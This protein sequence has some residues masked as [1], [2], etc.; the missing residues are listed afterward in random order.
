VR[1][2]CISLV[3][4]PLIIRKERMRWLSD[5]IGG[6]E[7]EKVWRSLAAPLF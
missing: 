7:Q 3:K 5:D 6:H 4:I 2:A 1:C